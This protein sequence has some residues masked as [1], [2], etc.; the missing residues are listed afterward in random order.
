MKSGR[1]KMQRTLPLLNG[2]SR[3]SDQLIE[4][5]GGEDVVLGP[6]I[7]EAVK[8]LLALKAE[9]KS[10]TGSPVLP[11]LVIFERWISRRG[12]Q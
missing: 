5:A 11:P 9:H 3:Q 12:K 6:S 4:S 7:D 10:N 2:G 8:T 1:Q